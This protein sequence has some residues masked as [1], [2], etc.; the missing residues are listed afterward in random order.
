MTVIEIRIYTIH[1]GRRD[2]FV[3]LCDERLVPAMK[4]YGLDV[5]GQFTSIED[6]DTFVWLRRFDSAADR[7]RQ[8]AAFYATDLWQELSAAAAPYVKDASNVFTVVPTPA[9]TLR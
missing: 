1:E 2:E 9:S 4:A 7:D 5:L 6:D 8:L 3:Q